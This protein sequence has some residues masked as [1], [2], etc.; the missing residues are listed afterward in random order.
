MAIYGLTQGHHVCDRVDLNLYLE[1]KID[2]SYA[3]YKSWKF[4]ANNTSSL[5][6]T[7]EVIVPSG[8]YYRVRGYHACEDGSRESTST[9]TQGVMIK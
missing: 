3:T 7:I 1:R 8:T 6:R 4:T 2:G 9:L 5:S